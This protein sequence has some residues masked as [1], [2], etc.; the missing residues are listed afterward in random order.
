MKKKVFSLMAVVV[1]LSSCTWVQLTDQ[2]SNVQLRNRGEIGNC[3]R[4]GATTSSTTSRI[5]VMQRGGEKVQ[6]ELV[7]LARN[8]AGLM[9]G[10]TI[11]AE[12][13]IESGQQR[14][15]VFNCP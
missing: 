8:E 2:G 3:T 5:V 4:I 1:I 7:T 15:S 13:T 9:G 14:F 10:N 12:S 11:V 6:E